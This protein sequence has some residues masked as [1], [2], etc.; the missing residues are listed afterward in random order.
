VWVDLHHSLPQLDAGPEQVWAILSKGATS[1]TVGGSPTRVLNPPASALLTALHLV[2]HGPDAATPR[3]DLARAIDQ[4]GDDCWRAAAALARQ[5]GAT[6]PLGTGLRLLPAGVEIADRLG[7][8]WA[9]PPMA[10]LNWGA[11][12]EATVWESLAQAPSLRS[13]ASVI[14]RLLCPRSVFLRERSA[15]ARRGRCGLALAYSLR[16]FRLAIRAAESFQPWRRA[17]REPR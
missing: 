16:P 6:A 5:L 7:L 11:P 14:V 12:W 15:L 17:R 2:H 10:L 4:L 8:P 1:I 13:R 3:E 9:V